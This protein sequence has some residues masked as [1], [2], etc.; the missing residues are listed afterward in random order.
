MRIILN[1]VN[2][3]P[4]R[5]GQSPKEVDLVIDIESSEVSFLIEDKMVTVPRSEINAILRLAGDPGVCVP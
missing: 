3:E 5:Y 4:E 2:R 1:G